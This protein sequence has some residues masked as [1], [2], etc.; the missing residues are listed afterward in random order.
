MILRAQPLSRSGFAAYGDVIETAG[1]R[2][3]PINA[4]RIERF[5]DLARVDAGDDRVLVSIVRCNQPSVLPHRVEM[6]ER[7]RRGSQAFIPIGEARMVIVVAA[8]SE[9]VDPG[10]LAAF[11][12]DGKQGINY[13]P[14]VWHMPLIA[15]DQ[16]QEFLVVDR[17]AAD[18]CDET[19]F[20]GVE[21]IVD[22]DEG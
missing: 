21:V 4:G 3:F 5:H 20:D 19:F 17:G 6:V 1:A 13:R 22:R 14:G 2:H 16:G 15:F 9:P 8:P 11:V 12:S 10:R 18:D 7:H